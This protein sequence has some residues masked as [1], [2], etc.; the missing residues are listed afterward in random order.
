MHDPMT[1]AFKI[2]YPWKDKPSQCWP[3]G[4]RHAF[5]TIWHKDPEK[6]GTDDSCGWFKRARHGDKELLRLI[7]AEYEFE[8]DRDYGGWFDK[9]GKPKF[10]VIATV[11]NMFWR[12][13][14]IHFGKDRDKA[15]R[16]LLRQLFDIMFFAENPVDSLHPFITNKYG[17]DRRDDR[18]D[19]AASVVYGWILRADQKWWQHARWHVWHWRI[20]VHPWQTLR[21]RFWDRCCKCGKRGFAKGESAMGDWSGTRIWHQRCDSSVSADFA[22]ASHKSHGLQIP[23]PS[24]PRETP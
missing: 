17:V 2:G 12:A 23:C 18:I 4:Y 21:R 3:N 20:Q 16:F 22:H 1:V 5:I 24:V 13:A 11:L 15:N 9:D 7:R 19:E 14:W 8:W 10:S 6:D